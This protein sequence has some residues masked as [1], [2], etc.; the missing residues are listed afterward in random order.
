MQFGDFVFQ[1]DP[2]ALEITYKRSYEMLPSEGTWSVTENS[3][4]ARVVTGEG[5]FYGTYAYSDFRL[6][7]ALL[8]SGTAATL[9]LPN[10]G[11]FKAMLTGLVMLE[12]PQENVVH[13]RF[14][15]VEMP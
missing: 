4:M 8:T 6:L 12:T 2:E 13:Y 11:A 14:T 1:S 9:T 10:W 15:F 7:S 3:L 5:Y